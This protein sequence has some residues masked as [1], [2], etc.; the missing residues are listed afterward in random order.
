LRAAA[1]ASQQTLTEFVL[2]AAE[3]RAA[4]VLVSRTVLPGDYFDQLLAALDAPPEP[5][6]ALARAA[7]RQ[8]RFV[9]R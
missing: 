3:D 4:E 7:K 5:M 1:D 9:Q 8:R 2:G 6:P